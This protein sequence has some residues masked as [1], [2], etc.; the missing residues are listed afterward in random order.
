MQDATSRELFMVA[1]R[2]TFVTKNEPPCFQ[3]QLKQET[4]I[5]AA[6]ERTA[7]LRISQ[8]LAFC[9]DTVSSQELSLKSS[10]KSLLK[11]FGLESFILDQPT[12]L[13][14]YFQSII[15]FKHFKA[16]TDHACHLSKVQN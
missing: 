8:V 7:M 1:E 5:S 16:I 3:Q 12:S 6:M 4:A 13:T 9:L 2:N 14:S 10:L 11:S 15:K